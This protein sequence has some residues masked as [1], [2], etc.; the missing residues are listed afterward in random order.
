MQ[1]ALLPALVLAAGALAMATASRAAPPPPSPFEGRIVF[2]GTRDGA[3]DIYTI[4]ADGTSLKRLT[5][6]A[7]ADV[8]PIFSRDGTRIIF[9]SSRAGSYDLYSIRDDGTGVERLTET[10]RANELNPDI[11][12]DGEVVVFER[13][14]ERDTDI[15]ALNLTTREETAIAT[16]RFEE[17]TPSI[18]PNGTRVAYAGRTARASDFELFNAPVAGGPPRSRRAATTTDLDELWPQ[19]E[20]SGKRLVLARESERLST[21]A[22]S[23]PRGA[24]PKTIKTQGRRPFAPT[25]SPDSRAIAYTRP[26]PSGVL[27]IFIHVRATGE[28][29]QL[30]FRRDGRNALPSWTRTERPQA[31]AAAVAAPPAAFCSKE[32]TSSAETVTGTGSGDTLC[33]YGG[34]DKLLARKGHDYLVLGSG[35]DR[36]F[37]HDHSDDFDSC[38]ESSVRKDKI[39]GD[40]KSKHFA[41]GDRAWINDSDYTKST[42]RIRC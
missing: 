19:F 22:I 33:G 23:G 39:W 11:S 9:A 1:F 34:D 8:T 24:V 42:A 27:Q 31:Q 3:P 14:G 40:F 18:S 25:W 20:P 5:D 29:R 2:E 7:E 12:A 17:V 32:G 35:N 13:Q 37:G 26:D 15:F 38:T 28:E 41:N 30:T 4:N 36:A 10:K 16:S 6:D 21:L